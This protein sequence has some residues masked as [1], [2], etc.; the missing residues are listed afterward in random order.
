[1][2]CILTGPGEG[3]RAARTHRAGTRLHGHRGRQ[4]AHRHGCRVE[5]DLQGSGGSA[6]QSATVT[7][8]AL[9]PAVTMQASP[10]SVS[11]GGSSTLTWSSQNAIHAP[12][13]A[14][15]PGTKAV[16]A[17][18]RRTCQCHASYP[19]VLGFWGSAS[20][21]ATVSVTSPAPAVS[22]SASPSTMPQPAAHP[23]VVRCEMRPLAPPPAAG[24][25][26]R[27]PAARRR[28]ARSQIVRPTR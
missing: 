15:G 5:L 1:M 19:D 26:A 22:I 13:P 21:S 14:P 7:V 23:D 16:S 6:T 17:Y 18:N 3:G 10:S 28:P 12:P 4:R 20:Q 2:K 24:R 27:R 8:S 25:A 11:S 9:P